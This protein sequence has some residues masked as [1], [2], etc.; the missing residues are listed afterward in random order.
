MSL[1]YSQTATA[2]VAAGNSVISVTGM[3]ISSILPGMV[4]HL[5]SRS[6]VKGDGFIISSVAANGSTGGTIRTIDNVDSTFNA[7][8]FVVDTRDYNGSAPNYLI[9]T[10]TQ[11]LNALLKLTSPLTNLFS[12]SRVL[13]LDKDAAPAVSRLMYAIAGRLWGSIEQ[14]TVGNIETLAIR[15]YPD[16]TTP[17]D[18]LIADLSTGSIDFI[19]MRGEVT[20]AETIDIGSKSNQVIGVTGAA[21]IVSFGAAKNKARD[22]VFFTSGSTLVHSNSLNLPASGQNITVEAGD[23]LRAHSD[24]NGNW[25][26]YSYTKWHGKPVTMPN[27]TDVLGFFPVKRGGGPGQTDNFISIGHSATGPKLA[28][29]TT[30]FGRIWLDGTVLMDA[31]GN[32]WL[33][34][35]NGLILQWGSYLNTQSSDN[36]VVFPIAFPNTCFIVIPGVNQPPNP[37]DTTYTATTDEAYRNRFNLRTRRVNSGGPTYAANI[38]VN[39][40][41]IGN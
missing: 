2:T 14:R 37:G 35:P 24:S 22:V 31:R 7:A 25:I 19:T 27:A 9:A 29:D 10:Y 8:G 17:L 36:T 3:D 34:L 13:A 32:G 21:R 4:I 12:G 39:W 26:I 23:R 11:V 38:S 18:A 30:D 5:G 28:V 6:R 20:G 33:T 1:I 41:A 40:F 15:A 16:G